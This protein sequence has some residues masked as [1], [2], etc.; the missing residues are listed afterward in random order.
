MDVYDLL[1]W[2]ASGGAVIAVSWLCERWAWFQAQ[3]SDV[4]KW[5]QYGAS[6]VVAIAALLIQQYVSMETLELIAPY[7]TVLIS[8]FGMIF[9]NQASHSLDPARTRSK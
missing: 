7:V 4:K 1:I 9:L 5:I 3:S 8:I 2:L 6:A